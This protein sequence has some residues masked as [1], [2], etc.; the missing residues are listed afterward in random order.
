MNSEKHCI[1]LINSYYFD[2]ANHIPFSPMYL[3]FCFELEVMTAVTMKSTVCWLVTPCRLEKPRCFREI[4]GLQSAS[5]WFFLGLFFSPEDGGDMFLRNTEVS[6]NYITSQPARPYFS[7]VL[8]NAAAIYCQW[9]QMGGTFETS[10][11]HLWLR[12]PQLTTPLIHP[13]TLYR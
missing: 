7:L 8:L 2:A 4:Y 5:S 3:P 11:S 6:F 9:S 1:N 12:T 10:N 13:Y